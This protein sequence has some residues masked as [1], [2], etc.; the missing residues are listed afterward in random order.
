MLS[1]IYTAGLIV[2]LSIA[3]TA[4][5][6]EE[7]LV[8]STIEGS[9]LTEIASKIMTTAYE[10]IGIPVEIYFTSGKRALALSSTGHV[11]GELVRIGAVKNIYPALKQV[12]VPN[13]ELKGIVFVREE[14]KD[15]I[16]ESDLSKLHVG[17]LDGIVQAIQFSEGFEDVWVGQSETELF[18]LLAS[19]KLDAVVSDDIDGVLAM[20]K[21]G[22][23]NVVPLGPPFKVEP[24]FHYLHEKNSHL[25]PKIAAVLADMRRNGD[26]Q[27]IASGVL[28][29][30]VADHRDVAA[31]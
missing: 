30:I 26:I 16:A 8:I 18:Q 9:T 5:A 7:R 31:N 23:T 17:Y 10:K 21:L 6:A 3:S 13:M 14:D 12:P 29:R 2:W 24:M 27:T 1:R 19:G 4:L 11:D 25:V 20:S 15:R 28:G 22:L